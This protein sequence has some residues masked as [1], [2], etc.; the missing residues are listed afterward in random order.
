MRFFLTQL[1]DKREV[2]TAKF[3]IIT[4]FNLKVL[5]RFEL[6]LQKNKF[7]VQQNL[8]TLSGLETM[9]VIRNNVCVLNKN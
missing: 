7:S 9:F 1:S 3:A 5:S 6:D 2:K 4:R 8:K